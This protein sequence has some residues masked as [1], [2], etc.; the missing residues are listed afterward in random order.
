MSITAPIAGVMKLGTVLPYYVVWHYTVALKSYV[1]IWKNLLLFVGHYFSVGFLLKT[2]FSKFQRI[3]EEYGGPFDIRIFFENLLAN[4][5]MR[6]VGMVVRG[7]VIAVAGLVFVV[8]FTIGIVGF[9]AW[10]ALPALMAGLFV[11]GALNIFG[12]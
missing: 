5:L 11:T 3:G 6:V 7:S 12:I 10:L 8:V 1:V 4:T 9:V 2:F